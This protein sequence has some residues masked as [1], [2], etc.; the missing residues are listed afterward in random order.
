MDGTSGVQ[1]GA[2][3]GVGRRGLW[4]RG[5]GAQALEDGVSSRPRAQRVGFFG[6]WLSLD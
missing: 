5:R 1:V 4:R 2:P 3:P 6:K